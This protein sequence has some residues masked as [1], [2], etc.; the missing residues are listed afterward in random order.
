M[1]I[2]FQ[3]YVAYIRFCSPNLALLYRLELISSIRHRLLPYPVISI[4]STQY[5]VNHLN[6]YWLETTTMRLWCAL[7][8]FNTYSDRRNAH[9]SVKQSNHIHTSNTLK[10][11]WSICLVHGYRTCILCICDAAD[12]FMVW[13]QT[14]ITVYIY[15]SNKRA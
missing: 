15:T 7:S 12:G 9:S 11:N 6:R 10:W 4:T 8:S 13:L 1:S 5:S 14:N 2:L 3:F